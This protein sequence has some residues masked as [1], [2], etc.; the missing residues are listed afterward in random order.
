M[1]PGLLSH[2]A[3]SLPIQVPM[4]NSTF[5]LGPWGSPCTSRTPCTVRPAQVP[6]WLAA[7]TWMPECW[8]DT[9]EPMGSRCP[10]L[11]CPPHLGCRV[12]I[13]REVRVSTGKGRGA[14]G[15]TEQL[16][17]QAAAGDRWP[18]V[19]SGNALQHCHLV[20]CERE[21]LR[22]RQDLRLLEQQWGSPCEVDTQLE[23]WRNRTCFHTQSIVLPEPLLVLKSP[24]LRAALSSH[25][26]IPSL[27]KRQ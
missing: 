4:G 21:V 3:L 5:T 12:D 11:G 1:R 25:Y 19:A 16:R 14:G 18:W 8:T 27:Q 9:L 24:D 22:P 17:T 20:H 23:R 15:R 6:G 26:F 2:P 13:C 7:Q 10:G